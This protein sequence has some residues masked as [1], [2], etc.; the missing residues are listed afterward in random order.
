M[1][2]SGHRTN[3]PLMH[4][5]INNSLPQKTMKFKVRY[6]SKTLDTL[7]SWLEHDISNK[8]GLTN[9]EHRELYDFVV[10][11]VK[12]LERV[13]PLPVTEVD[14]DLTTT[15]YRSA[16]PRVRIGRNMQP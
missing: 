14:P 3:C 6:I 15:L 4:P 11:E 13:D 7:I 8:A 12:N 1:N 5:N 10:T 16:A 2:L 9:N